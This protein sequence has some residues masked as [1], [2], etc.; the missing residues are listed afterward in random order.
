M[1]NIITALKIN[2][3]GNNWDIVEIDKANFIDDIEKALGF[4]CVDSR[5]VKINEVCYMRIY[6]EDYVDEDKIRFFS[7]LK[8][9]DITHG[10]IPYI[11]NE[12][13][14]FLYDPALELKEIL[15][16]EDDL[17]LIVPLTESFFKL[18]L[19]HE[20]IFRSGKVRGTNKFQDFIEIY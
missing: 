9:T 19:V 6:F 14:C 10:Y 7:V 1:S 15:N 2:E 11:P 4:S 13:L 3:G 18:V 12:C 8:K 5:L 20:N 17:K 16:S